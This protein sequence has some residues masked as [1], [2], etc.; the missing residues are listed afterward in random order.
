MIKPA[1]NRNGLW[2][3]GLF[4]LTFL[5]Y[6]PVL[7]GGFIWDDSLMVTGNYMLR[8][9]QGLRDF[10]CT[11][12]AIDPL[13]VTMSAL[14]LQWQC[15]GANPLGYHIISVLT[16]SLGAFLLWRVLLRFTK[17]PGLA[18]LAAEIFAVH[19]VAVASAG[20]ISEQKNT[21]S[22]IF[23]LLSIL[24]YLRFRDDKG[25]NYWLSLL[26]FVLAFLSKGSVVMLPVVLLLI[27]GWQQG[28]ITANDLARL[29]P[30][31]ALS[32]A[33][34][35]ATIWSQNHKAIGGAMVQDLNGPQRILAAAGAV[36]FYLWKALV[37]VNL[38]VIY[39]T[40]TLA[41]DALAMVILLTILA[42]GW[43]WR[44]TWGRHV[45]LG[46]GCYV[47]TLFPVMGLFNMY[48][49]VYS[50]VSDHWQYLALP[51]IIGLVVCGGGHYLANRFGKIMAVAVLASL[52]ALTWVRAG[53]YKNERT[54][55]GDTVNRNPKAW[56]AW[57]NL[58]TALA[59]EGDNDGA[60]DAYQKAIALNPS[61]GDAESNL[62][63]SLVAQ[64]KLEEANVHLGK[65]T[66]DQPRVAKFH[67]NYGVGLADQG[68]YEEAV[69]QY[70]IALQLSRY[71]PD[72][73]NNLSSALNKQKKFA[74]A[75]ENAQFAI[76]LDPSLSE[77]YLNTA[78]AL[79]G[80][81]RTNEAARNFNVYLTKRPENVGARFEFGIMLAMHGD[82]AG[83][84]PQ[85]QAVARL[86]PNQAVAHGNLG[87]TYAG[88]KRLDEAIA[89]YRAALR[90]QPQD[91]QTH[92]NLANA[93]LEEGKRDE[94]VA[95]YREAL[96]LEPN[97]TVTQKNLNA[98]LRK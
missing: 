72:V 52:F 33:A 9:A 75:L 5:A 20:W 16:H 82:L 92:N 10:W 63:N 76:Q 41:A 66:E 27:T 71:Q 98:A 67:F 12:R 90:L 49:L 85:L 38:I 31:F 40:W 70:Q 3:L 46:V 21:L 80:L 94:A 1:A 59:A 93:L 74:A 30:F 60:I 29:A 86:K 78:V 7:S 11:T 56:M 26:F 32:V 42:A 2:G 39:P 23:Y 79:A 96:R 15:W 61:F 58:G 50:R 18:W 6:L 91:A 81:D 83:A 48:F 54:I 89:E 64:N 13:P 43:R 53:V 69:N 87:N 68:R 88:L 25:F 19:P 36:C 97:D 34:G 55:W 45:L 84:L 22:I 14:W 77:P 8:T 35:L 47:V 65:A 24:A 4:L 57:N 28:R 62:G 51:A 73:L 17:Q 37:P 44:K 95:E